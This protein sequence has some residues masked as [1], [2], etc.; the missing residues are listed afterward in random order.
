MFTGLIEQLGGV[1]TIHAD[2]PGKRLVVD[3]GQLAA[4][5]RIGDSIAVN[6]C[7]LTVVEVAADCVSFEAGPETLRC[8]NLGQVQQGDCVN[9]ERSLRVGDQMGGHFVTGTH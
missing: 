9:I 1:R 6:G 3:L 7:C 5:A 8:T 4:Q 2:P